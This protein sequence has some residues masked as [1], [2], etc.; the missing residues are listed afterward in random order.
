MLGLDIGFY[1]IDPSEP[2]ARAAWALSR[3]EST[4]CRALPI[5]PE[6]VILLSP[7]LYQTGRKAVPLRTVLL[8][9]ARLRCEHAGMSVA[10][11]N[12]LSH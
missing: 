3:L 8:R 4:P 9:V 6:R 5:R 12:L 11:D 1:S 2:L 10:F 7:D